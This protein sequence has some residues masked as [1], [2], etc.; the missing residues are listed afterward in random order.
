MRRLL[1]ASPAIAL[2]LAI[3]AGALALAACAT[4]D[5]SSKGAGAPA[6]ELAGRIVVRSEDRAF[7]SAL[8]WTQEPGRDEIWFTA[9]L[10]QTI[11]HLQAD[12][13]L[14]AT[15]TAADQRRYRAGSVEGLTRN[16][17]GWRFPV[18]GLRHWVLGLSAP[19]M[20]QGAIDRDSNDRIT[21][22][23]QDD[24]EVS[25]TYAEPES[26]RPQRIDINGAGAVIRLVIDS[27]VVAAQ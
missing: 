10:G 8:R 27:L 19:G 25:F 1:S 14:G 5:S 15:L 7:T 18:Q 26:T 16:A 22:L 4:W 21:R 24:W 17:L 3:L 12:A 6:F 23:Q 20:G 9:P 11:A 13:N 2:R